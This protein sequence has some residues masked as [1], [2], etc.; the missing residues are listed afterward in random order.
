MRMDADPPHILVF[1][2]DW[3]TSYIGMTKNRENRHGF[4]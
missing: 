1:E 2:K 3:Q 4:F